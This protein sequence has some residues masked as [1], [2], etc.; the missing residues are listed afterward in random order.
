MKKFKITYW[1][2]RRYK[3]RVV[4]EEND[5]KTVRKKLDE[6]RFTADE[7][8]AFN[9]YLMEEKFY[10]EDIEEITDEEAEYIAEECL[11]S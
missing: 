9:E 4:V 7:H 3:Y 10:N 6:D 2:Q 11:K 8:I 1:A 5:I